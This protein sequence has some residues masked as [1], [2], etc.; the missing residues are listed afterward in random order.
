MFLHRLSVSLALVWWVSA[1]EDVLLCKSEDYARPYSVLFEKFGLFEN[2]SMLKYLR[3]LNNYINAT[4]VYVNLLV[5]S[6]TD[7]NEKAQSISTQVTLLTSWDTD[8]WWSFSDFCGIKS[9]AVPKDLFWIPDIVF[10]ESIKT[11]FGANE[12][13]YLQLHSNGV[14]VKLDMLSLTT[15]CK[16]DLYMFPFDTQ[17]CSLTLQSLVYEDHQLIISQIS[18]SEYLTLKSQ[19][20]FET[21]GEWELLYINNSE[22]DLN[23]WWLSRSHMTFQI[24]IRRRP[25]LYIINLIFPVFCFLVLDLAS[26]FINASE[27]EKLGFK[28]TLLLSISVLLLI[29]NDKLPSTASKIPLIGM[30]CGGIF[31][32]I[33]LSI[34]E[35]IFVNY[36]ITKGETIKPETA[37]TTRDGI[38][39]GGIFTLI[40]LS[41]LKTNFV[42]YLIAKGEKIKSEAAETA[43]DDGVRVLR[44]SPNRV[45]SGTEEPTSTEDTQKKVSLWTRAAR[46]I[47]VTFLVLYIITVIVFL[48][49]LGKAWFV[50]K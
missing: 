14:I 9:F 50:F 34:L 22:T 23:S 11:E 48:S 41:I 5:T 43:H 28:V 39:C 46:I 15:V 6:I 13:P 8:I 27:A 44:N 40:G 21:E 38:Y 2:N 35:T 37:A 42:N 3:A 31:T 24:F 19:E 30:Y 32:L 26:Y 36:L 29:L 10:A 33:G 18:S 1:D 16:M 20:T 17:I 12:S 4:K 25:L 45:T 49:V 47:D 7:V